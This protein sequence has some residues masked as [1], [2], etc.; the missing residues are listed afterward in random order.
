MNEDDLLKTELAPIGAIGIQVP[1]HRWLGP[2]GGGTN[3]QKGVH[4]F[5]NG[6]AVDIII[7]GPGLLMQMSIVTGPPDSPLFSLQPKPLVP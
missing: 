7:L 2:I 6:L 4:L 3:N 5:I 1:K